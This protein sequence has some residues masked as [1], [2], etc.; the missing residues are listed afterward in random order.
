MLGF[1]DTLIKIPSR[2]ERCYRASKKLLERCNIMFHRGIKFSTARV[3]YE[4]IQL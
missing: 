4:I 3:F 1:S 2:I